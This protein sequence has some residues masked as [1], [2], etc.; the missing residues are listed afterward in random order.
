MYEH[1]NWIKL[2]EL[3]E[4]TCYDD[5]ELAFE[6]AGLQVP[7]DGS[8]INGSIALPNFKHPT[9]PSLYYLA[10]LNCDNELHNHFGSTTKDIRLV[11]ISTLLAD[12]SH[13]SYEKQGLIQLD[14]FLMVV[15]I[16]ILI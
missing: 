4:H 14:V 15:F 3:K 12:E 11:L 7:K 9:S 10:V 6:V 13:F 2:K 1:N 5:A 8:L 16:G